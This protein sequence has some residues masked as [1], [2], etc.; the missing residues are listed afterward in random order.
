M[1]SSFYKL[2]VFSMCN[3]F[4]FA[5][6]FGEN[7]RTFG[8]NGRKMVDNQLLLI[9]LAYSITK[10]SDVMA[11]STQERAHDMCSCIGSNLLKLLQTTMYSAPERLRCTVGHII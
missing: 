5:R 10:C 7:G 1:F 4:S 11:Q 3:V 8:Q 6:T 9:A 2:T